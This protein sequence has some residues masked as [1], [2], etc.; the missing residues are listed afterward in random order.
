MEGS[1]G[2][3]LLSIY[4]LSPFILNGLS[5]L[6]GRSCSVESSASNIIAASGLCGGIYLAAAVAAGR[7]TLITESPPRTPT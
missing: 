6:G 5:N 4:L 7:L 2:L 3:L 1:L